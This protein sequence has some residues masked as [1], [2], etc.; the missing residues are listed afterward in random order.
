[1]IGKDMDMKDLYWLCVT[2]IKT[3]HMKEDRSCIARLLAVLAIS[4]QKHP[5]RHQQLSAIR[6][7]MQSKFFRWLKPCKM[8]ESVFCAAVECVLLTWK[9]FW[10]VPPR[11]TISTWR[12]K[13]LPLQLWF[14][15]PQ[16]RVR[17]PILNQHRRR[18]GERGR[19]ERKQEDFRKF[20]R[21]ANVEERLARNIKQRW[22][23]ILCLIL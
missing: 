7:Q 12:Q 3:W 17:W 15:P 4:A 21:W 22:T 2:I 5:H 6:P 14:P 19:V 10:W 23:R 18:G 8:H 16:K 20:W 13:R 9:S 11:S 1:M